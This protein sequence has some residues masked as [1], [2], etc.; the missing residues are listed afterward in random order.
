LATSG[1]VCEY[2]AA[3]LR[4]LCDAA[5]L[6]PLRQRGAGQV[7]DASLLASQLPAFVIGVGDLRQRLAQPVVL[8]PKVLKIGFLAFDIVGELLFRQVAHFLASFAS[9][10]STNRTGH[11]TMRPYTASAR[12]TQSRR[13]LE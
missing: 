10:T 12:S 8:G 9:V 5:A 7:T 4:S 11:I 3:S 13:W 2:R 1:Q 6:A